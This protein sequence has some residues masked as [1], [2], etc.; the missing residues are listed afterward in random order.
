MYYKKLKQNGTRAFQ[1]QSAEYLLTLSKRST[2]VK[3]KIE[4]LTQRVE[5]FTTFKY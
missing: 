4:Q 2:G 3:I 1:R 5:S